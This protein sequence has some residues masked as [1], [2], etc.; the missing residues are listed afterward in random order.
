MNQPISLDDADLRILA[1][2]QRDSSLTNR[3][4]A[5]RVGLSP[6][7]CLRRTQRLE[8]SGVVRRY[9]ALVDREKVGLNVQ[10][11]AFVTLENHRAGPARQFE[12]VVQRRHE[13]LEC[14]RLS[15]AFD[16]LLRVVVPSMAAYSAFLDQHL[17]SLAAVR[18]VNSSFELGVLKETTALPVG[19]ADQRPAGG[20]SRRRAQL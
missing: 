5:R 10:A 9:V 18:S 19:P 2:L 20:N 3:E 8:H 11:L 7:P 6:A 4:L 17:L 1:A 16:Y 13:V 12:T 15:G 14:L